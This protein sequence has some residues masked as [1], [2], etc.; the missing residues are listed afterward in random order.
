MEH[1]QKADGF[2]GINRRAHQLGKHMLHVLFF[3]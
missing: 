2:A 1:I 3:N